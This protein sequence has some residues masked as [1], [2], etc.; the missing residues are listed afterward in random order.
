MC[1]VLSQ[2]KGLSSVHLVPKLKGDQIL[3]V[4]MFALR[5]GIR[6]WHLIGPNILNSSVSL[7]LTFSRGIRARYPGRRLEGKKT[8]QPNSELYTYIVG[9][10]GIVRPK[11]NAS[12]LFCF[13]ARRQK[14]LPQLGTYAKAWA[15]LCEDKC[16]PIIFDKRL[17]IRM[18]MYNSAL[19]K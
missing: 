15:E 7:A 16:T 12:S 8:P 5:P 18:Y 14:R 19:N 10:F 9:I 4:L 17:G 11:Q 3:F 13:L 2:K 1:C 6:Y